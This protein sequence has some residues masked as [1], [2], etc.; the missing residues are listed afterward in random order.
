MRSPATS[1]LTRRASG[2]S[3]DCFFPS[4]T[5]R[6][7]TQQTGVTGETR[8]SVGESCC[9]TA[10]TVRTRAKRERTTCRSQ[11]GDFSKL[12][13]IRP[14]CITVPSSEPKGSFVTTP[15]EANHSNFRLASHPPVSGRAAYPNICSSSARRERYRGACNMR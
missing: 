13:E 4:D 14:C 15:T 2:A 3:R 11:S 8:M 5:W 6:R 10:T 12:A 1:G 9:A 7:P